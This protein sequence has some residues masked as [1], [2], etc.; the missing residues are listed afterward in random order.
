MPI[1]P[2]RIRVNLP[3]RFHHDLFRV[4]LS[5]KPA[6]NRAA[7]SRNAGSRYIG[8]RRTHHHY[9]GKT[10]MAFRRQS[11]TSLS[12]CFLI[13]IAALQHAHAGDDKPVVAADF[14]TQ[15][16]NGE[17]QRLHSDNKLTVVC[18]LGTECPLA[19]LYGPR[20][21]KLAD[22]F[23]SQEVRFI[24][25]GS[26]IQD[27]VSDLKAYAESYSLV[28]PLVK[29]YD[30]VI[31]DQFGATRTPE[32]YVLDGDYRVRYQGRIDNQYSPGASRPKPT[33]HDLRDAIDQLLKG[34]DV[35]SPRVE[36]VGCIIGRIHE[37]VSGSTVTF[38][39]QVS[40]V[41]QKNC[42][43]CH[44]PDQIGPFSLTD[45]DEAIGWGDMMV[46]VIDDQRMPPW[47]ANPQHGDFANA[48]LMPEDEKQIIRDWVAAGM[49]FGDKA[50]L[51]EP[52]TF[53][54]GWRLP[55]EPDLV[56][57]MNDQP[58][59]VP[60]DGT[61]EYQYFVVDP[62]FQEDKWVT[63]A[64]VMPGNRSVVHHSIVFIRPPDGEQFRGVSWLTAYVPGQANPQYMATR[65]RRVPAGS[66]LVFQQHYTPTGTEQSDL[67]S[68]G[69]IFGDPDE[70]TH[71]AYTL[72]GIDQEFVIPPNDGNFVVKSKLPWYPKGADLLG[73][74]P[75]MHLRG[76]SFRLTATQAGRADILLD[77][78]QYDFNWQH[79]YEFQK[80]IPLSTIDELDF[81][82]AF[83]NSDANLVNPNP[84]EHVCWGDQ[85]WEEMAVAFF[86]IA[87]PLDKS[88][89][90]SQAS[91]S[92]PNRSHIEEPAIPAGRQQ[93]IDEFVAKF[94]KRFDKNNDAIVTKSETPFAFQKF[95]F[96][97]FDFDGDKRLDRDEVSK[98]ATNRIR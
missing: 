33:R 23:S 96:Y 34:T 72:I 47:H 5:S 36:A 48:R 53:T 10:I 64:E 46:E 57:K 88:Q 20:L 41:L 45:Y 93:R 63:M 65:A 79:V 29:D 27:S 87:E 43:E 49:P 69:M 8:N 28:F 12:T 4:L 66:K 90:T 15:S 81:E 1:K 37:P 97:M 51:P 75:H 68:I 30:N 39:N 98:A 85:T 21:Q 86:E 54:E 44:R 73:V 59:V 94:F 62:G 91:N 22:E 58:F 17:T 35:A 95:S 50:Q 2:R 14:T 70:I 84:N 6:F 82:V 31:A 60:A 55:R 18:F 25:I 24:G 3:V 74:S 9:P 83:D 89:T 7:L 32:V 67:T 78:P 76:K 38:A 80:P 26:N 11:L 40:R 71:E 42:V 13:I 77:V 52:A 19:K 56:L 92:L 16:I 61:V